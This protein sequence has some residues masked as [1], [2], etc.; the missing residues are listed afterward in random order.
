MCADTV[1]RGGTILFVGTKRQAQYPIQRHA[2]ACG[3]PYVNQRWLGGMLTNF[4]TIR[5]RVTQD[6]R[7]RA[8]AVSR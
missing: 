3:M 4:R 8:D 6:A 7:V 5:G 1:A 2:D